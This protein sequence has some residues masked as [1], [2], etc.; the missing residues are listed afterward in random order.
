MAE[1]RAGLAK[2]AGLELTATETATVARSCAVSTCTPV[3][4]RRVAKAP[5][6][7]RRVA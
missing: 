2:A 4:G 5:L 3:W 6:L 7:A 1:A